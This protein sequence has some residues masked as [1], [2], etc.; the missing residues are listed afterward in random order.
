MELKEGYMSIKDLSVWFGLK[1]ETLA[2]SRPSAKEKKFNTLKGYADYHFEGKKLYIDKV[3]FPIYSK[4]FEI[5]EEEMPKRW[6]VIK[7]KDLNINETLKKERIDTSARVGKEIWYQVSTV[8]NA[9]S[10]ETSQ[11]YTNT[12]KVKKYGHNYLKD[13]G[14]CGYSEYVWMNED[15]SAPLVGEQLIQLQEC[16]KIAYGDTSLLIAAIDDEFV[17]GLISKEE[18]DKAVG[19]IE[20]SSSHNRFVELVIEKLGFYPEKRTRIIDVVGEV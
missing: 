10:I 15:G 3:K 9:I 20:T 8:K 17:K 13:K 18:R 19:D 16:A 6:G 5:I 11:K 7:D 1:P 2:K 4:A 14:T 12:V